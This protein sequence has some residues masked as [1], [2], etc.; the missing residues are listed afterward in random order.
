MGQ[1]TK[2]LWPSASR[3][4]ANRGP[5]VTQSRLFG[6]PNAEADCR[7]TFNEVEFADQWDA[8][9]L[10][11]LLNR[12]SQLSRLRH[13]KQECDQK[14]AAPTKGSPQNR[15]KPGDPNE[16]LESQ[17]LREGRALWMVKACD[18]A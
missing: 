8:D 18:L 4:V 3:A 1:D 7:W 14:R 16:L 10:P 17:E 6:Q 12:Y 9:L 11:P 13:I 5:L 2:N 15:L